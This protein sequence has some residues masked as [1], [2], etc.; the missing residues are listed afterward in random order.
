MVALFSG[1][2]M[3]AP[4]QIP[5][6]LGLHSPTVNND[7]GIDILNV[8]VPVC[9][10]VCVCVCACVCVCVCVR[11]ISGS[12]TIP[13]SKFGHSAVANGTSVYSLLG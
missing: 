11:V 7:D 2:R 1:V 6:C 4:G 8:P 3:S 12:M 10:C 9:V 13:C 5:H